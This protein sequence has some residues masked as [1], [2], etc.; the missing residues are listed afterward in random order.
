ML[1]FLPT[2]NPKKEQIRH[3][4]EGRETATKKV[5]KTKIV[6]HVNHL[7]ACVDSHVMYFC[8]GFFVLA[9]DTLKAASLTVDKRVIL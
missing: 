1:W 9:M 3:L 7:E 8:P 4:N 6:K 5:I 2:R